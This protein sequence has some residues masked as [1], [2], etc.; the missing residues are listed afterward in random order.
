MKSNLLTAPLG[1]L[2]PR[3]CAGAAA[4]SRA[5]DLPL[6][7]ELTSGR[8]GGSG[9]SPFLLQM[10]QANL[11]PIRKLLLSPLLATEFGA[12][13]PLTFRRRRAG[14]VM[15]DISCNHSS[16]GMSLKSKYH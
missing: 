14:V 5:P 2:R 9:D 3:Y 8:A 13:F 1:Q 11:W 10:V 16:S 7:D 15:I 6:V 4:N 12:L